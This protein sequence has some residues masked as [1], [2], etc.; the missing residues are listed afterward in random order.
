MPDFGRGRVMWC[1]RLREEDLG[2]RLG[3]GRIQQKPCL[4]Y[5]GCWFL[6]HI[7]RGLVSCSQTWTRTAS[8]GSPYSSSGLQW[9][10]ACPQVQRPLWALAK[11]T[12][13]IYIYKI[14]ISLSAS[15]LENKLFVTLALFC[16]YNFGFRWHKKLLSQRHHCSERMN[17]E[18]QSLPTKKK[19]S[20][21]LRK[22]YRRVW[23]V[24]SSYI[25]HYFCSPSLNLCA[26][27]LVRAS[28]RKKM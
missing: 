9:R 25:S 21:R 16:P 11:N 12:S 2:R 19:I 20:K 26:C 27:V 24:Y 23:T 1:K 10:N 3:E 8:S 13:M 14:K 18:Q 15:F 28:G 6:R 17:T 22:M 7:W 5:K 4:I